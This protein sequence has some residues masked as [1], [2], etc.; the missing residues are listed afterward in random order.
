MSA[1]VK[2]SW[3]SVCSSFSTWEV[4]SVCSRSLSTEVKASGCQRSAEGVAQNSFS[5]SHSLGYPCARQCDAPQAETEEWS[6]KICSLYLVQM[7]SVVPVGLGIPACIYHLIQSCSGRKLLPCP[8]QQPLVADVSSLGAVIP[9]LPAPWR[10][11]SSQ[12]CHS[13]DSE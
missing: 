8:L 10:S 13:P 6:G 1:G 11:H 2:T 9:L 3:V 5:A 7:H 4:F 12:P